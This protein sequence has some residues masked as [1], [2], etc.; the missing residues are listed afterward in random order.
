MNN[1]NQTKAPKAAKIV[2]GKKKN[3]PDYPCQPWF[4]N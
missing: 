2:K 1:T 4:G 3:T